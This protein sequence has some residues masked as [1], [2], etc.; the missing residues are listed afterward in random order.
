M[1]TEERIRSFFSRVSQSDAMER[2]LEELVRIPSSSLDPGGL[3][4][5]AAV[6][7]R[8]MRKLGLTIVDAPEGILLGRNRGKHGA[9]GMPSVL[10]IGHLDTVYPEDSTFEGLHETVNEAGHRMLVGPGALDMKGGLVVVLQALTALKETGFLDRADFSVLFNRDEELGS[11]RSAD[12][13]TEESRHH[14]LALVFEPGFDEPDGATTLV[15]ERGGLAR[16][17]VTVRGL[18]AHAGNQPE[19]GLNAVATAARLVDPIHD[20]AAPEEGLLVTVC[21]FHGGNTINQVPGSATLGIDVRFRELSL[22]EPLLD[23]I[24]KIAATRVDRNVLTGAETTTDVEVLSRKV[25]MVKNPGVD[26]FL[27]TFLKAGEDLGQRLH[28]GRRN[29]TSDGNNTAAAGTPTL[30]GLGV[31]GVGMHVSGSEA[32]RAS[33]LMERAELLALALARL[34]VRA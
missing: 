10:L 34:W 14:D 4:R 28:P 32:L 25:P 5:M 17:Q 33:S 19:L 6:C 8:E 30:D 20:L 9:G 26:G 29:G 21:T 2:F 27:D 1:E 13:I 3:D 31:V 11:T 23:R 22:W 16:L 18:E 24:R 15:V 7:E 12:L